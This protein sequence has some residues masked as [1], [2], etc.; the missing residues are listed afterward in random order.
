M[1]GVHLEDVAIEHDAV[2]HTVGSGTVGIAVKGNGVAFLGTGQE[3]QQRCNQ[4]SRDV[5]MEGCAHVLMLKWRRSEGNDFED[6]GNLLYGLP[7]CHP[8]HPSQCVFADLLL[9][10]ELG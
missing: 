2:Q 5:F 3:R 8:W 9:H 7:C 10:D 6:G 4:Q 1:T